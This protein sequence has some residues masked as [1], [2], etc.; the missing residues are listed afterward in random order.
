MGVII[1][2]GMRE[3]EGDNEGVLLLSCCWGALLVIA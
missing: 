1:I 3:T 2:V